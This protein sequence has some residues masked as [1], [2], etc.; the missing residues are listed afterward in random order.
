MNIMIVEDDEGLSRGIPL[1]LSGGDKFFCCG[2]I[3]EAKK[4]LE[5][6]QIDLILLD[7][8][9]PDGDG[10]DFCRE[11]RKDYNMPVLFLTA[12]DMEY[13]EVAGLDAGADDYITKPFSLAV[14]RSRIQAAKRRWQLT[15]RET[16][17]V[18]GEQTHTFFT[19][20]GQ[21]KTIFVKNQEEEKSSQEEAEEKSRVFQTGL[22]SFSFE[23]Q[24]FFRRETEIFLS[25][26]EQRLLHILV[27]NAGQVVTREILFEKIWGQD[28]DFVD[29]NA[30]SVTVGRLR[31]K[32]S[33]KKGEPSPIQTIYGVGYKWNKENKTCYGGC[34]E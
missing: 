1:A 9:L 33:L 6:E 30:L 14:L 12:N 28:G 23:E 18:T 34:Q 10:L 11:I 2:K 21:K 19:V 25:R 17:P 26:T 4:V 5:E 20:N 32:L 7:I 22:Y 15:A 16:D 8:G 27:M 29:E 13:D 24:R 31:A 3:R